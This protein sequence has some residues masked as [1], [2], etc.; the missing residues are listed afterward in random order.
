MHLYGLHGEA[1][2]Q[3]I[4][5]RAKGL[6]RL[7]INRGRPGTLPSPSYP[8]STTHPPSDP[9]STPVPPR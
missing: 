3:L 6:E 8:P 5:N 9:P 1:V 7:D 2:R 4:D